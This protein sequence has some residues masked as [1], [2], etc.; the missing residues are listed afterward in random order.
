MTKKANTTEAPSVTSHV[1]RIAVTLEGVPP[2]LIFQGK[3]L[4][5]AS[6]KEGA[7]KVKP[8]GAAEEAKLHAH[9]MKERGKEV[10][11][12]PWV[13]L[14]QS[15][16]TAANG[17]KF[18]GQKTLGS[19]VAA[20]IACESDRIS[21]G[22]DQFETYEEWV[23]IPPRTGAMVMI[24]RPRLRTWSV[25]FVIVMDDELYGADGLQKVIEHAGKIIGIGAWRAEKRGPYGRFTLKQFE[26]LE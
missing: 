23:K 8:R 25:N 1:R 13:M 18:K 21:L 22:T 17:F 19:I 10:L 16:C 12:I 2:G 3:G 24:G 6:A 15:F 26:I 11:C 14:Y 4:M 7:K 20:T 5:A 9:W